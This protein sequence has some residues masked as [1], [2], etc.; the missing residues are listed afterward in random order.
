MKQNSGRTERIVRF[1]MGMVIAAIGAYTIFHSMWLGLIVLGV[2]AFT[3]FEGLSGW[4]LLRAYDKIPQMPDI[5]SDEP[6]FYS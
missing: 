4:T 5:N 1:I 3:V 6:E 2:G